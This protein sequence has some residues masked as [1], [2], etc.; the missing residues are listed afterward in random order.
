MKLILRKGRELA[1]GHRGRFVRF[2]VAGVP[3]FLIAIPLNYALVSYAQFPKS[4]AYALVLIFQVSV[5]F[6]MCRWLVFTDR[7]DRNLAIQ[8]V[9]FISSILGFRVGDWALYSLAVHFLG[10]PFILMQ[11]ANIFFFAILKYWVSFRIMGK[12]NEAVGGA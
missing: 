12:S 9:L 4:F 1:G 6:F 3:S 8:F 2:L 7:N 10:V 5:N 11:L